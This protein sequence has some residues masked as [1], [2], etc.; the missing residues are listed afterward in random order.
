MAIHAAPPSSLNVSVVIP[1]HN[2]CQLVSRAIDSAL[3]Q[4]LPGDEVIVVDDGSTDGTADV[5]APYGDRII[6]IRIPNGGAGN[7]RN[8]GICR[9]KNPLVAFLDSD[10]EWLPGKMLLQRA[11][12]AA[13]PDVLFCFTNLRFRWSSG[14]EQ[15][16]VM[17]LF[18]GQD[19]DHDKFL[20]PPVPLASGRIDAGI[21][22]PD[23]HLGDLYPLQM[24]RECA[25]VVTLVYRKDRVGDSVLFPK[26]LATSEDWEF[27]GRLARCGLAAYLNTETVVAHQHEGARITKVDQ[28]TAINARITLLKRVWGADTAFLQQHQQDYQATLDNLLWRRVKQHMDLGDARQA[29]NDIEEIKATSPNYRVLRYVPTAAIMLVRRID[30]FLMNRLRE[31]PI[32]RH[33]PRAIHAAA[34]L[35][36]KPFRRGA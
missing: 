21:P 18:Y 24:K 36:R 13:Q 35:V 19:I 6:Y 33:L 23:L 10:D 25:S 4:C 2:R 5:L 26:D 32:V 34:H 16:N 20:G 22:M 3:A 30:W 17:S 12:L 7:A 8:V 29:R 15:E 9:A 1:T 31:I 14:R 11:F 27:V 28:L